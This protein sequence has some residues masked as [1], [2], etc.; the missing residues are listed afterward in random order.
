MAKS[1]QNSL[2]SELTELAS[3]LLIAAHNEQ[4]LKELFGYM[5]WNFDE[6]TGM[7]TGQLADTLNQVA[8]TIESVRGLMESEGTDSLLQLGALLNALKDLFEMINELPLSFEGA[9]LAAE[10]ITE[11]VTDLQHFLVVHYLDQKSSFTAELFRMV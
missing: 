5:G 3:P 4:A 6:E 2:V 10:E 1:L 8:L 11:I 7:L 9:E